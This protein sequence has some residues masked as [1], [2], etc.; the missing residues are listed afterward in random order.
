MPRYPIEDL[1]KGDIV[2]VEFSVSRWR[3]KP[4]HISSSRPSTPPPPPAPSS[5]NPTASSAAGIPDWMM[6][7]WDYWA[8]DLDLQAV[9]LLFKGSEKDNPSGAAASTDTTEY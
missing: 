6:P 1:K 3:K 4:Q 7:T 5:T 2:L 8:V 9:S